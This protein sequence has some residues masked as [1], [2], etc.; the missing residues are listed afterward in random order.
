MNTRI[1]QEYLDADYLNKLSDTELE[2]LN[3]FYKEHYNASIGKAEGDL[4][5]YL[6]DVS[7]P[8]VRKELYRENNARNRDVFSS[9][10]ATGT[11]IYL[12]N[13]TLEEVIEAKQYTEVDHF[14][15]AMSELIK[16]EDEED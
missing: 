15:T 16:G 3:Q 1:R 7:N 14:E 9:G 6:L 5:G 10:K 11:L 12:D 8:K 4:D 13:V 2:F